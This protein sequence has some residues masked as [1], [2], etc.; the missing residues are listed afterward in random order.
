[1]LFLKILRMKLKFWLKKSLRR[2]NDNRAVRVMQP[3]A[4]T[5]IHLK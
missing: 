4:I 2:N 5:R 1:M 3:R